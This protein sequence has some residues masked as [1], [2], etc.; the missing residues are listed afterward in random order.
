MSNRFQ[1][2]MLA[3]LDKYATHTNINGTADDVVLIL[4]THGYGIQKLSAAL[5][6]DV[7]TDDPKFCCVCSFTSNN[8]PSNNK[9]NDN[10]TT[11]AATTTATTTTA[12]TTTKQD[13]WT[14][15]RIADASHWLDV[16]EEEC[17]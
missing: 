17:V 6:T 2:T 10:T 8:K 14:A 3:L 5:G 16:K 4:V 12:T 9:D 7:Q 11:T 13:T 15:E 1:S